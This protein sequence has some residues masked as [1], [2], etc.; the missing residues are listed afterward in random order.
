MWN[1][2]NVSKWC[3]FQS[4]YSCNYWRNTWWVRYDYLIADFF[5]SEEKRIWVTLWSSC[6]SRSLLTQGKIYS[7]H[8]NRDDCE[9]FNTDLFASIWKVFWII[10]AKYHRNKY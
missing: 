4:S 1:K 5:S 10:V 7:Q 6:S 2:M 8:H 3:L 9:F